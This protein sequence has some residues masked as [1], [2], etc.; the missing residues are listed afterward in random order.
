MLKCD[1][2][3]NLTNRKAK[4]IAEDYDYQITGYVMTNKRGSKAIVDQS[5]VRWLTK[6]QFHMVMNPHG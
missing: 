5:A 1:L 6:E 3:E 2:A 4:N